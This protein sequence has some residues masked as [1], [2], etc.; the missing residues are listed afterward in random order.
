MTIKLLFFLS[1][2]CPFLFNW[3]HFVFIWQSFLHLKQM[4]SLFSSFC[5]LLNLVSFCLE[6]CWNFLFF[7]I[8]S[9]NFL[10]IRAT[11][12][13]VDPSKLL[14]K[15]SQS[16]IYT[17]KALDELFLS[18][19]LEL[20]SP[21]FWAAEFLFGKWTLFKRWTSW[22]LRIPNNSSQARVFKFLASW[23]IV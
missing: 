19:R 9:L 11:S 13:S 10:D 23:I 22:T 3:G 1:Q 20:V 7:F 14:S 6:G 17:F 2:E 18:S 21:F 16:G 4:I 15:P 8:I 5:F 12:S